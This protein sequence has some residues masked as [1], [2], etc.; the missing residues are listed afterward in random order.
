MLRKQDSEV[1]LAFMSSLSWLGFRTLT[2]VGDGAGAHT[3]QEGVGLSANLGPG[4]KII[5]SRRRQ[6]Y[7]TCSFPTATRGGVGEGVAEQDKQPQAGGGHLPT[8]S[9]SPRAGR[10]GAERGG[11]SGMSH[12]PRCG[13]SAAAAA[14]SS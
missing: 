2:G 6:S 10:R 5:G 3:Y 8:E 13:S 7:R 1:T 12:R 14:L 11:A 4:R 9:P